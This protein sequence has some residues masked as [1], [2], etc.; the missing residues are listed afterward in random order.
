MFPFRLPGL[1]REAPLPPSTAATGS[2]FDREAGA[3]RPSLSQSVTLPRS[4]PPAGLPCEALR[5]EPAITGLDWSFAPRP[6]S[7]ERIARQNP[8]GP[9]PGFRPASPCPGLDRPVSGLTAVTPGPIRTPPLTGPLA[10]LRACR[11][12]YAFGVNPLRL[13]TAVNS[14]A[15]VSRRTVRPRSAPFVLPGYPGF[16]QGVS[17]LKS[18]TVYRRPVSGSFHPPLGV[19]FSFPSRY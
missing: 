16:L 10:R 3:I 19:L 2:E 4:L 7:G 9:P 13:A 8:F 18:R 17:L 1:P 14:P 15:R 12:P 6:G 5:R 11:F